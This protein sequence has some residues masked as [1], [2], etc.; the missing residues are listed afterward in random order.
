MTTPLLVLSFNQPEKYLSAYLLMSGFVKSS[1]SWMWHWWR[2]SLPTALRLMAIS[3]TSSLDQPSHKA[4]GMGYTLTKRKLP[5]LPLYLQLHSQGYWYCIN[6]T[7]ILSDL[8]GEPQKM[9][10]FARKSSVICNQAAGFNCHLYKA[11]DNMQKPLKTIQ[12]KESKGKSAGRVSAAADE[13]QYLMDFNRSISQAMAKT[14]ESP[15]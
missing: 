5:P 2:V 13:L 7:S 14:M 15:L 1:A 11:Q 12:A 3:K 8:S 10:K 4:G 6:S 9:G